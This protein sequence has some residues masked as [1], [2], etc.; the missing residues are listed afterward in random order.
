MLPIHLFYFRK[1][2]AFHRKVDCMLSGPRDTLVITDVGEGHRVLG[3]AAVVS[4][5]SMISSL[6][7]VL[8]VLF[9]WCSLCSSCGA[10]RALHLVLALCVV[11]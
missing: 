11:P 1:R 9:L 4:A 10:L 5:S 3:S 2:G 7:V 6:R 8:I